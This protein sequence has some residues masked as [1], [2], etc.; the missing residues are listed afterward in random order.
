MPTG[1][2]TTASVTAVMTKVIGM[3]VAAVALAL[4]VATSSPPVQSVGKLDMQRYAGTW[5]E[6][7]R[8]P[9]KLEAN[10]MS[11]VTATYR[12]LEDGSMSLIHR[13]RGNGGQVNVAVAHVEPLAG[14]A[15]RLR[16]SYMPN[17]LSWWPGL[18]DEQWIVMLDEA[19][20]YAVVSHP[21]RKSLRILSRSPSMD[22]QSFNNIVSQL[23]EQRYPVEH[24]I[25]TAQRAAED[26][27]PHAAKPRL[28]V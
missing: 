11:D 25:R 8:V 23:R 26:A 13:C 9:N 18:H 14:D 6:L 10:C 4:G 1:S 19:Y 27:W 15:A 22:A 17:W 12:V 2:L 5:Y 28:M 20:R 24:L 3:G 16:L 7:A 21:S